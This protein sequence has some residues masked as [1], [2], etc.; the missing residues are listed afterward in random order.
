MVSRAQQVETD[1]VRQLYDRLNKLEAEVRELRATRRLEA[2]SIGAG[3]ITVKDGGTVKVIDAAG[4]TLAVLG[5]LSSVIG[6]RRGVWLGR[7]DGSPAIAVYGTGPDDTG[8]VGIYDL[9]GNYIITDDVYSRRGLGRPY[10]QLS[11]GEITAPTATTTSGTFTD[12]LTGRNSVQHPVLYAYVLVRASDGTTAGEVRL[13]LD[14]TAVGPTI[15]IAAGEYAFK[16]VGPFRV[17]DPGTYGSLK[18]LA[19]QARRTAGAGNVGV[20]VMSILGLESSWA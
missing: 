6:G 15:A 5:D 16:D 20:R 3:G 13:A 2:A 17:P 19:V 10:L 14:G 18:G 4:N 7:A 8:F 1:P 9:S 12:L 11:V